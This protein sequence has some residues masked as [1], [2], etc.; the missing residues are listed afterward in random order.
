MYV[1]VLVSMAVGC[2]LVEVWACMCVL[3]VRR[4]VRMCRRVYTSC[5]GVCMH[6]RESKKSVCVW[7]VLSFARRRGE[8]PAAWWR[9]AHIHASSSHTSGLERAY[10]PVLQA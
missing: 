7:C 9:R 6:A 5:R 10:N 2:I 4:C 1:G 3:C 8:G